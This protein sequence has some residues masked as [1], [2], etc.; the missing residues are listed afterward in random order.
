MRRIAP[1]LVWP[2]LV[3][4]LV[5]SI[6]FAKWVSPS[7]AGQNPHA[8]P[9]T[10][11]IDGV[12]FEGDQY[13]VHGWAC[14]EGNR[15]SIDVHIYAN[16]AAGD[17]PAGTFVTAGTANLANEPAVDRECHDADGGKHRFKIALPNQMMRTFEG[18]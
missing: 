16:H 3:A 8:G 18:K 9:V 2:S 12:A 5:A 4:A 13:Y 10:G 7:A 11:V 14:Q 17:K 6:F 1:K 15:G